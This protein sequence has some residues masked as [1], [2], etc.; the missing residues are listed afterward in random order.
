MGL[1][2]RILKILSQKSP[3][4]PGHIS[5]LVV[6]EI[7]K[8]QPKMR[9]V[10]GLILH[11]PHFHSHWMNIHALTRNP[12]F[13]SEIAYLTKD[14]VFK[15]EFVLDA[16]TPARIIDMNLPFFLIFNRSMSDE[17]KYFAFEIFSDSHLL[18]GIIVEKQLLAS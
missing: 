14:G 16:Y 10:R 18:Q 17:E 4:T 11:S 1:F 9:V 12:R 8:S 15:T 2:N 6:E 5:P 7:E 13:K 3:S